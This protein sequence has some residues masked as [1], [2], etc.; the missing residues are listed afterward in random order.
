MTQPREPRLHDPGYPRH[1]RLFEL[2]RQKNQ[3]DT[4]VARVQGFT[5]RRITAEE[6]LQLQRAAERSLQG[7][8]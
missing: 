5:I 6:A 3:A 4:T 7:S 1:S 2:I 8:N